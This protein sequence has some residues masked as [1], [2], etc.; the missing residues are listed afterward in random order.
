MGNSMPNPGLDPSRMRSRTRRAARSLQTS[1]PGMIATLLLLT[2]A[3]ELRSQSFGASAALDEG[4]VLIG[5][6]MDDRGGR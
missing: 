1:V 3:G 6:P 5:A 2:P 4:T